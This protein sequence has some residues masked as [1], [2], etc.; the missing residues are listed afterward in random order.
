M[1]K[2]TF[3]ISAFFLVFAFTFLAF[4]PAQI[5]NENVVWTQVVQMDAMQAGSTSESKGLFIFRLT[6]DMK[7]TYK[8]I[9][10]KLDEG[11]VLTNA[12]IHTGVAGVDGPPVIFLKEGVINLRKFQTVQLTLSQYN[13]LLNEDQPLYV[14]VHTML[15]P[16]DSIRGQIR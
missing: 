4:R 15:I 10:Q 8:F 14:N 9:V 2:R 12:H 5:Y 16:G 6:S 1:K 7:L 11:D 13:L 3:I